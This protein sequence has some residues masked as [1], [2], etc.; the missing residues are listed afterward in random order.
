MKISKI[1]KRDG[2]VVDFDKEWITQA[3][4][5][6]FEASGE[7]NGEKCEELTNNVLYELEQRHKG[8]KNFVPSIE[9]IQDI[10]EETLIE[11]GYAKVAKS[12]ILYRQK[13]AEL[14]KEKQIVLDKEE[15]DEVDKC[16]DLNSLRVLK[17]RYLR[18][19]QEGTV[20]ES[21]KELF[22]RVAIHVALSEILYDKQIYKKPKASGNLNPKEYIAQ[23]EKEHQ[24]TTK[25]AEKFS[26]LKGDFKIGKYQL[27]PFHIKFLYKA[28]SR[29]KNQ[30][31]IAVDFETILKKLQNNDFSAHEKTVDK[32]YNLMVARK[33]F[34]NTP[35]LANFGNY[36]GM[37]SA[38]FA[39]DIDDSIE[40]IMETLKNA[41]V[42]FKSGGGLGYNFSKLRPKGDFI[43]K[44][45]GHS[46]GPLSFMSLFDAMTDVVKQGGIR[47]GANM[48][49]MNSSHPD[50][51]EFIT[52][53]QGNKCM[54][55]FNISVLIEP[56]FWECYKKNSFYSLIN[57]RTK[58]TQKKI[59]AKMMFDK[60]I[61]QAW[62][63]GEPG[64][65]FYDHLNENNPFLESLGPLT[66]TNP[67]GELPLYP[68]ESCNLG[69]INLL[70]FVKKEGK[71]G[72][73][74]YF[75]WE[76]FYETVRVATRFL[77]NVIDIN[78]FPLAQIEQVSLN[79][80]KIGLG[81]M[82]LGDML[83]ALE[84]PYDSEKGLVIME[85]MAEA[86]N[87]YSK[88]ESI[89]IAK[90]KG[91]FPFY[92]KTFYSKG[93]LPFSASI[94]KNKTKFDWNA[95]LE[96]IKK[97][98]IRNSVTTVIA[99]TGSISMI[100]G[101]SSGIEPVYSL[102]YEK[103]VVVGSFYYIDHVFEEA[104][105]REGLFDE[106]LINHIL[107]DKGSVQ[108]IPYIPP[109]FKKFFVVAHDIK[110]DDH[111]KALAAFQKWIDSSISKTINF[112]AGAT[113]EDMKKAYL[114]AYELG[115]KDVTVF[116][117]SSI[118]N[119]VLNSQL[120]ETTKN[121]TISLNQNN[122]KKNNKKIT[123][124]IDKQQGK[125]KDVKEGLKTEKIIKIE[126]QKAAGMA[127]YHNP[128]IVATPIVANLNT[129]ENANKNSHTK[130]GGLSVC[131]NCH[132]EL[133]FKEGCASCPLCGWGLCS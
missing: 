27:N 22:C 78:D 56:E 8:H 55:N 65:I 44:T 72:G 95:V 123:N 6:A 37:G 51:E 14:R 11:N 68:N 81:V 90:Q 64:V 122:D 110:P 79:T 39:L 62:E 125:Y 106:N 50:I 42:I 129:V 17:S 85:E 34:P 47:R 91:V 7:K 98:G 38:C 28:F 12:Y 29:F 126:D 71:R 54:R 30:N 80:R 58:E 46:S 120:R 31:L 35:T 33:F 25:Q 104:M 57:P 48:G 132:S 130:G 127:L 92:R 115:C 105:L 26:S 61:Y 124:D 107:E 83:F 88:L 117:D 116:R 3:I 121:R 114:L 19:N 94:A 20:I 100:A 40:S 102:I 52:V 118:K 133:S 24:E 18:K 70:N 49:I 1:Q 23:E 93:K 9:E 84:I 41:A 5:K 13:R 73:K 60:I 32:F 119:Q 128:S 111:I 82:G 15:I 97:H 63:S 76:D 96:N 10:V 66:H 74:N 109:K 101:C 99:P 36:L 87:Y 77:D 21:P 89:E 86:L 43:Q 59:S 69:S 108:N 75:D 113:T 67:C 2:R 103:N 131:P 53:K 112:S 4:F 45:G 16:F